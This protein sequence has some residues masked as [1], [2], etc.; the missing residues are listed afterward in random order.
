MIDT[1]DVVQNPSQDDIDFLRDN[2]ITT[3]REFVGVQI[4]RPLAFFF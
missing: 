2:L 4:R 1:L 3:N